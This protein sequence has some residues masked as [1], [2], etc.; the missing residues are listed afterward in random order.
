MRKYIKYVFF[1][2]LIVLIAC[3]KNL[4]CENI[5]TI[6]H[7]PTALLCEILSDTIEIKIIKTK[8]KVLSNFNCIPDPPFISLETSEKQSK[9]S[10]VSQILNEQDTL[11]IQKQLNKGHKIDFEKLKKEKFIVLDLA[12]WFKK[13]YSMENIEKEVVRINDS[14]GF[15]NDNTILMF[16]GPIINKKGD[17][18]FL[19]MDHFRSGETYLFEKMGGKWRKRKIS[20]WVE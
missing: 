4:N 8:K 7:D 17:R 10:Y 12:K 20:F 1:S 11:F 14:L 18:V 3:K 5:K 16:K 6:E 13:R 9:V 15:K 2:F 19:Q